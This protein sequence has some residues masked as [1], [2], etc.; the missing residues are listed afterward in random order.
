MVSHHS[1]LFVCLFVNF[2]CISILAA[3]LDDWVGTEA[4]DL[5][6]FVPVDWTIDIDLAQ[7]E[8][9]L[10]TNRY[11]WLDLLEGDVENTRLAF[12]GSDGH[13]SFGFPFTEYNPSKQLVHFSA[14]VSDVSALMSARRGSCIGSGYRGA[15]LCPALL[16]Q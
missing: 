9:F 5:L 2:G 6:N 8:I 14:K 13:I 15:T 3:L 4:N 7:Y 16:R 11:N 10:F 1:C 12:C